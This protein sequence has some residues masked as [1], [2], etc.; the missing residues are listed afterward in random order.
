M[1]HIRMKEEITKTK[2]AT[3]KIWFTFLYC[4]WNEFMS[5]TNFVILDWDS[6]SLSCFKSRKARKKFRQECVTLTI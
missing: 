5:S 6:N 4:F 1:I 3:I 2:I